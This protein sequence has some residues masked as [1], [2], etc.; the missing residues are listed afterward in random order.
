[1]YTGGAAEQLWRVCVLFSYS[2]LLLLTKKRENKQG[3]SSVIALSASRGCTRNISIAHASVF[4]REQ[5]DGRCSFIACQQPG[6]FQTPIAGQVKG[7][8]RCAALA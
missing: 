5:V 7:R 1:M 6:L 8:W 4:G 2:F 3:L